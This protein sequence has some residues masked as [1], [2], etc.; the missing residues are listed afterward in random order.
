MYRSIFLFYKYRDGGTETQTGAYQ[1]RMFSM[2]NKKCLRI[3][4]SRQCRFV[5]ASKNECRKWL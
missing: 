1:Q 3:F 4:F 5:V 2:Y